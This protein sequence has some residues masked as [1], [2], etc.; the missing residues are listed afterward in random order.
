MILPD[1]IRGM[2]VISNINGMSVGAY[3]NYFIAVNEYK[4]ERL[5]AFGSFALDEVTVS[6]FCA[7]LHIALSTL[8]V[9]ENTR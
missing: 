7:K 1:L 4:N 8:S 5:F 6:V 3:I 9:Y 2:S